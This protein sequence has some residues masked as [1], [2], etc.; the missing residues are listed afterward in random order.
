[1]AE[2]SSPV[3][4]ER[5]RVRVGLATIEGTVADAYE[6]AHGPRVVVEVIQDE[7][8]EGPQASTVAV[9]TDQIIK[10]D[11]FEVPRQSA[12][13]ASERT[14]RRSGGGKFVLKRGTRG[15]F[16]FNLMAGDGRV[17]ATS[18]HYES[19]EAALAGIQAVRASDQAEIEVA[20]D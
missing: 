7:P 12:P 4:G 13:S 1:L 3:V 16:R 20:A 9:P 19:R 17:I 15:G 11:D 14:S 2:R 6:T 8:D 5:V 10:D 18:E